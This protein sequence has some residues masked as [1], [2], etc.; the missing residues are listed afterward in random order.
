MMRL[1]RFFSLMVVCG[2]AM[3]FAT[4]S[5]ATPYASSVRNTS[6]NTWEFVLNA[7][8]TATRSGRAMG[9]GVYALTAD[10]KGVDLSS[11]AVVADP[12]DT[13]QAKTPSWS[14]ADRT[15]GATTYS[16]SASVF[17]MNIDANNNLIV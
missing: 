10:Q 15:V 14:V 2:L 5:S 17:R 6:G 4:R 16:G 9:D 1:N 12:N 8:T 3:C 13:T 7:N 11:F